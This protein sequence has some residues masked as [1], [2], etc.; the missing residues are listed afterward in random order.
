[1]GM[2]CIVYMGKTDVERQQVNVQRMKMLGATV[3]PVLQGT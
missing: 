1:M 3:C 2:E